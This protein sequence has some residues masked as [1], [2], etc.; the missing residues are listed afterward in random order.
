MASLHMETARTVDRDWLVRELEDH[1]YEAQLVD[2]VGV[3]IPCDDA[4]TACDGLLHE[5]ETWIADRDLP[6]VPMK[7]ES[8]I[9]LGPPA[10]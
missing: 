1:G 5:L 3:A 10:G 9:Y 2:E 7:A 8:A 4:A 6:L